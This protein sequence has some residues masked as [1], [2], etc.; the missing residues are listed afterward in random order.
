MFHLKTRCIFFAF[1]LCAS[2]RPARQEFSKAFLPKVFTSSAAAASFLASQN[3][4]NTDSENGSVD[5]CR[6][7]TT[8]RRFSAEKRNSNLID[9]SLQTAKSSVSSGQASLISSP[10][11]PEQL[12]SSSGLAESPATGGLPSRNGPT[13]SEHKIEAVAGGVSEKSVVTGSFATGRRRGSRPL[14]PA[15]DDVGAK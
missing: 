15:K 4:D 1:V 2:G 9:H 10:Q 12:V 11:G 6:E 3:E 5:A 13:A 8:E 14:Q 7:E